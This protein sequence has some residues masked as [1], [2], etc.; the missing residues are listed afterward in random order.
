[1]YV[2]IRGF[3]SPGQLPQSQRWRRLWDSQT[4]RCQQGMEASVEAFLVSPPDSLSE[5]AVIVEEDDIY[6]IH[7]YYYV[8]CETRQ[9]I[10]HT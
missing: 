1:M 7:H 5:P 2:I 4:H 8:V 9:F 3:S 10:I 6:S